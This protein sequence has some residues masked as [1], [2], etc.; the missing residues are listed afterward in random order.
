MISTVGM[1]FTLRSAAAGIGG[2]LHPACDET[3]YISS[4]TIDS[5]E[6]SEG[7]LFVPLPGRY[8]DGHSFIA[9][10]LQSGAE[11]VLVSEERAEEVFQALSREQQSRLLIV[12]SPLAA[13]HRLARWYISRNDRLIKI[14]ISGSNGKTTTKE[15]LYSI[16]SRE[17]TVFKTPGNHNSVIGL[18]VASFALTA[19]HR[20]AVFELAMSERGE[21]A[22][23]ARI[24]FP[25]I[26]VLT[27]IGTAHIG[28]IGSQQGIAEE[29]KQIFSCFSGRERAFLHED[30]LYYDFLAEGVNGQVIPFGLHH[31]PGI[32]NIEAAGLEGF[33][34]SWNGKE[35]L[36]P[37]PGRHNMQNMLAAVS[38]AME[39]GLSPESVEYG[40]ANVESPFGRNQVIQGE[41]GI[42]LDCYNANPDSMSASLE[43]FASLEWEGRK[44]AVLGDMLELGDVSQE[45]HGKI[46]EQADLCGFDEIFW[47]GKE[48][49]AAV[50]H[51]RAGN[52]AD[53]AKEIIPAVQKYIG[54][55][56][57]LLL[58]A[59]R[60]IGLETI[61]EA[62]AGF[63]N[64][65]EEKC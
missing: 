45:E 56:D 64:M 20:Y 48:F 16:L 57:L 13:L 25:D 47:V 42:I 24:V 37:L 15:I 14:A 46:V 60:G 17:S 11:L 10:A 21:M 39:L 4:V 51:G 12:E 44:V 27:N 61:S 33:R 1:P 55:G 8:T 59:S 19:E 5:R 35:I 58:K 30:E 43:F 2:A 36:F 65:G 31:T 50:G 22:D 23:L 29:K 26:A 34:L 9:Q 32:R 40:I 41:V 3:R 52:C 63:R 7:S 53:S 54:K 38:V 49:A 28:N 62:L 6:V 18:P